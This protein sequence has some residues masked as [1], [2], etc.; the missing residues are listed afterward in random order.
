MPR[1]EG[2]KDHFNEQGI[3]SYGFE[4][5][6]YLT[7]RF[8]ITLNMNYA[9]K[10]GT[11]TTLTGRASADK[12]KYEQVPIL[13]S[14]LYRF[15]FSQD[16]IIVPFLGG[17]YTHVIYMEEINGNKISGD[18]MGYHVRG[19]L[20]LLLDYFDPQAAREFSMDYKIFNTY[21]TFEAIYSKADDFGKEV[22][23]IGGL[24]YM[25]G[26]RFEY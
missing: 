16:Q 14:I 18:R 10:D 20:E 17:G 9:G 24:G 13:V 25:M 7:E 22:I 21:L 12:T 11:A 23:D 4:F 15:A 8:E 1:I 3:W 2:W 5:G 26:L 6:K 19:G